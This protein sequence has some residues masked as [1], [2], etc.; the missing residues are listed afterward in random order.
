MTHR[1]MII[2]ATILF[3]TLSGCYE[4]T[5]LSGD[6]LA[7]TMDDRTDQIGDAVDVIEDDGRDAPP[8]ARD[9]PPDDDCSRNPV[10][11]ERTSLVCPEEA[12]VNQPVDISFQAFGLGC[13]C[14]GYAETSMSFEVP[15]APETG[16]L[17]ITA[18]EVVCDP[19]QCCVPCNCI[20]TYH[21]ELA[22][23]FPEEGFYYNYVNEDDLCFTSVFG[24]DGCSD[25]DSMWTQITDYTPEVY[26]DWGVPASANFSLS[27]ST[28]WCCGGEAFVVEER[29]EEEP[30][31][32][33]K[34]VLTPQIT[35][36]EGMC[37]YMCDCLDMF[38]V[39]HEIEGLMVGMYEVCVQGADCYAVNVMAPTD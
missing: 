15:S 24:E 23:V 25:W 28:G 5:S 18:D 1:L 14:G 33:T 22:A 31:N 2:M 21:V 27:L 4:E 10:T 39:H 13:G 32:P 34:I 12:R 6:G 35:V 11:V 29:F 37:C 26:T 30:Y 36:C 9:V 19:S 20:D 3:V 7:D 17:D 16:R 38:Q 8:D